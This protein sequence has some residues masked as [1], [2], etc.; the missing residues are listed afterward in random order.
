MKENFF[1]PHLFGMLAGLFLATGLVF[2]AML[3][4]TAWVKIHNSQFISVKG[5]ARKNI[6]SDLAIW[7]GNFTTEAP[8]LLDA[9]HKLGEDRVKVENF[10]N[11]EGMTNHFFTAITIEEL[12]ATFENVV[13][14]GGDGSRVRSS[15]EK[16]TG[17]KLKQSVEAR[18]EDVERAEQLDGESTALVEQGVLLTTESPRFIYTKAAEAKIEML[19]EATG[20][21]RAR[22]EQ[23]ASR[24][25]RGLARLY[26]ADMGI[27]Q[28][29]PLNSS[30]TSGEGMND[31]SSVEKTITAVVTASF[32]LE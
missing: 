21:A 23:I 9:Q 7:R 8:T 1:K 14:N 4:T 28:I 32:A 29:T 18:S 20:D 19:A 10:L 2:S 27:F 16:I 25:G 26:S 17:Y 22:A 13:T 3:A 30:E 15:Q 5:S 31:T 12:K 24:G 11:R 6:K